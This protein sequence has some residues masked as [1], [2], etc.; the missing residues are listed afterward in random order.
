MYSMFY[1]CS[2]FY[3]SIT[4][5]VGSNSN[6]SDQWRRGSP[7]T[8]MSE[9]V[10]RV[11]LAPSSKSWDGRP[12]SLLAHIGSRTH[13]QWGES[14]SQS[15]MLGTGQAPLKTYWIIHKS[16]MHITVYGKKIYI[17]VIISKFLYLSGP[18]PF[19]GT[20]GQ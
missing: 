12:M 5:H 2:P 9:E 4:E 14:M 19:I 1:Y 11:L 8:I 20:A 3:F 6:I 7:L 18:L 15:K 13:G 17:Y 10:S 16:R